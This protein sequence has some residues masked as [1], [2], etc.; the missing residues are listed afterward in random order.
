MS[1]HFCVKL[2]SKNINVFLQT[3][4]VNQLILMFPHISGKHPKHRD[5]KGGPVFVISGC[6]SGGVVCID[7]L[8]P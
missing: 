4:A 2:G 1:N 8:H 3:G 7:G 6:G 5:E